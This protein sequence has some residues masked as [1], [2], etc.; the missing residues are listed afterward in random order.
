MDTSTSKPSAFKYAS[1]DDAYK[2]ARRRIINNALRRKQSSLDLSN[3]GLADLPVEIGQLRSLRDLDI[4]N[5]Q[6]ANLPPQI[7]E[8]T[9][10][11]K[12]N[13]RVNKLGSIPYSIGN[14]QNLRILYLEKNKIR[15]LPDSI[16]G[17]VKLEM[18]FLGDNNLKSL[19][20]EI[21]ALGQLDTLDFDSNELTS[22]PTEIGGLTSLRRLSLE[23]N[24]LSELTDGIGF[25]SSLYSLDVDNNA[26][27]SL[28]SQ[29][30]NLTTLRYLY[31]NGNKFSEFPTVVTQLSKLRTLMLGNNQISAVPP[32]ISK[33]ADLQNLYLASNSIHDLPSEIAALKLEKLN[34]SSNR[35][36]TLPNEL[37]TVLSLEASAKAGI[38]PRTDGLFVER[39]DLPEPYP[40]L[41]A[42]GQPK[43]TENV[44]AWLRGETDPASLRPESN[45][46]LEPAA[47][48]PPE[49]DEEAGP[50]FHVVDGRVDLVP[51]PETAFDFD[52]AIQETLHQRLR[53]QVETLREATK[54]VGNQHPQLVTVIDEY[55]KLVQP[56]IAELDVVDLWAAGNALMAQ[57]SSFQHQDKSRTLSEPLEPSHLGLLAEVAALHGSFIL[58]F[59]RAAE[60]TSRADRSRV[61]PETIRTIGP[62][63]SN[64]LSALSRQRRLLSDRAR[65]LIEALDAALLTGSW[66]AARIGYTSY[67]TVRNALVA[68]GRICI[69]INDKG[70]SLVGGVLIGSAVAAANLPA[71]TLQLVMLFL[72][73]NSADILSFAAPFPE[74]RLYVEWIISHFD[75]LE[76]SSKDTGKNKTD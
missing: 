41:I 4:S 44:L 2:A 50:T 18:L 23:G 32:A 60:L 8:L 45:R 12:L 48:S 17:L 72:K 67:A 21:G 51:G 15:E 24:Q 6:L 33:M 22:L 38:Q 3:F 49:P 5:N 26:L 37:G 30:S 53:R 46:T 71:D 47:P 27:T 35:L 64:V 43:S 65:Q 70:G 76:R 58:G 62:P 57:A 54:K 40:T 31:L 74:L 14:L 13:A 20:G 28:P 11:R 39:N 61:G 36:K 25:L 34:L 63:T 29:L 16:H 42:P 69:W 66:D 19:P 55:D 7:G 56:P 1:P 10:L 73:S 68:I 9:G 52:R 59:P 75:D